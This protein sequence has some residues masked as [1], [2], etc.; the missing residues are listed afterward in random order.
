M[1]RRCEASEGRFGKAK[2]EDAPKK[3][4]FGVNLAEGNPK[5]AQ[6]GA[7]ASIRES[8]EVIRGLNRGERVDRVED[9]KITNHTILQS[10][11]PPM[12][13]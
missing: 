6:A 7:C 8:A 10:H 5:G 2:P 1:R 12:A 11:N 3:L 13:I 9:W 4:C